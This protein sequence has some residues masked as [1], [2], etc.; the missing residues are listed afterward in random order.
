MADENEEER[1]L[2]QNVT[3]AAIS[4][5]GAVPSLLAAPVELAAAGVDFIFDK[6]V[7]QGVMRERAGDSVSEGVQKIK[8]AEQEN[9]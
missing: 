2:V 5:F 6:A 3:D 8:S 1:G 9:K 7:E 4:G